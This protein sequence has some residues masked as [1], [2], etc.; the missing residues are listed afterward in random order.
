MRHWTP[1]L[2][3]A[4]LVTASACAQAEIEL[5]VMSFNVRYGTA[6][7]GDN[8]WPNR[9]DLLVETIALH[10]PHIVGTQETLEFQA[11]YIVEQLP[12]YRW[13]GIGRE[14]NGGGEF[15]A[16]L[17]KHA[18]LSPISTRT[19]WLSETPGVPASKSWDSSL[20]R[21]VT[22]ALFLHRKTGKQIF[23]ANTHFDHRGR[24]ARNQSAKQI[25][26]AFEAVP[27]ET[28]AILIGDFNAIGGDS[29]P[30]QTLIDGGF[31]DAWVEAP[32]TAGP[33]TTWSAFRAPDPDSN[34]RIDW[35]LFRGPVAALRCETVTH[36]RD[37]QYP[38]DHYPVAA[39]FRIE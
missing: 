3:A 21:I 12:E 17:Y 32:E 34:R 1:A 14:A 4:A 13:F 36:N 10:A 24:E 6:P 8:A 26:R 23:V 5:D 29:E 20:P 37:G 38:S 22:Y 33:V 25:V 35:I 15:T 2:L 30:W 39:R 31:K 7:D 11:E 27:E 19:E 9:K 18:E 28:P 16:I